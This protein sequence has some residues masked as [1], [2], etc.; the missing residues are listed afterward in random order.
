MYNYKVKE[1][2]KIVDGDTIYANIDLGFYLA[3]NFKFR[4]AGINTPELRGEEREKGL[5]AKQFV[6]DVLCG[7][8][9]CQPPKEITIKTS[10]AGKYGRW[11]ADIYYQPANSVDTIHLNQA[12]LDKGLA[13]HY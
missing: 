2:I 7:N 11:L 10:K 9:E 1:I 12:L 3:A 13:K 6:M 4:L 5:E 8:T